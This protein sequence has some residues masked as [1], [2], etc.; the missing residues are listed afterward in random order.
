LIKPPRLRSGDRVALVAPASPFNKD[1]LDAGVAELARL[2][3]EAVYDERVLERAHFVAG[4]PATRTAVIE[5]A[6]RDPSIRALIA[7]RGGYGSAQLLPLLDVSLLRRAAKIFVGYSDITA[8]LCEHLRTGVV[9]FH[10]AMVERR[11]A[12][13]DEGYDRRSFLAALAEPTPMGELAPTGLEGIKAGEARGLLVGGTLT[14]LVSLLGTP[15]A[16]VPPDGCILFIEDVSERPYRLDR[17][18]TQLAHAGIL[19]RASALVCGEF[20]GCGEPDGELLARHVLESF[21]QRFDGPVL[22][23]FPSGHTTGPTWTLPFGVQ[24]RVVTYPRAALVIEE[25]AVE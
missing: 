22:I 20:P 19:A 10:G 2:G 8:L 6:W 11:L 25:A 21:A 24:A 1:D 12:R 9:C 5:D 4:P 14:Q 13:G 23:G 15:W 3:Y 17:M 16:Y 7:I 18:L